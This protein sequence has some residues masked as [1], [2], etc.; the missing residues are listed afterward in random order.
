[1][2][3]VKEVERGMGTYTGTVRSVREWGFDSFVLLSVLSDHAT[4][5]EPNLRFLHINKAV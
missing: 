4:K 2:G 3:E 1:M 5:I